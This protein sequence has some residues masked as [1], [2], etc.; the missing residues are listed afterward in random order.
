[1]DRFDQICLKNKKLSLPKLLLIFFQD[2]P[3][4]INVYLKILIK[5]TLKF[6]LDQIPNKFK[7]KLK[8]FLNKNQI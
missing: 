8:L 7:K 2:I 6:T 1:M 5:L 4:E 3:W